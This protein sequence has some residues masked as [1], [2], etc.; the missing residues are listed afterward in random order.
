MPL[1]LADISASGAASL[2]VP[3][4]V[5]SIGL[6]TNEHVVLCLIDGLGWL[7]LREH[8]AEAPTL[9]AFS[10]TSCTAP[11]PST[12]PVGLATLGTGLDPGQHGVV[13]ASFWLPET[14]ALLSPLHWGSAPSPVAVQPEP[15]VFERASRAGVKVSTIGPGAYVD[16]GLTRAVLRG[17]DY[18][19]AEDVA[20]RAAMLRHSVHSGARTLSY[21]YWPALDRLGH[22]FGVGS[23]QWLSGLRQVD[24]LVSALVDALSPGTTMIITSDHGMLNIPAEHRIAL[25][26]IPGLMTGVRHIA[27]EPRVRHVYCAAGAAHDVLDTWRA[28]L[29]SQADVVSR[30]ELI[31]SG[32]LGAVDPA[33]EERIGDVVAIARDDCALAS[34][35][36][37]LVSGLLGQHGAVSD[38]ELLVPALVAHGA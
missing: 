25:E 16:S 30:V 8:I 6:G 22:E 33:L 24:H 29:G 20:D 18:L 5:D 26:S 31:E 34:R 14:D 37:P 38:A 19:A 12:T 3:E 9:A 13:G 4:Y 21:V 23:Q 1:R 15:T 10:G 17:G 32:R 2:G 36:D 7:Q 27:G 28:S 35:F 11:F